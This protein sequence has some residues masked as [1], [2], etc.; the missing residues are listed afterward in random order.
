MKKETILVTGGA[1]YI[2]SHT[3][4]EL[5]GAGFDVFIVDDLSNSD[6]QAIEGIRRITGSQVPFEQ[7]DCCDREAL[8]G[9]FERHDFSSVIHFAASKAV[10]E[11][12][13]QPLKYYRNNILSLVNVVELTHFL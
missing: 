12:V 3:V 13:E 1:G 9:V 2:G 5:I 6:A 10:G 11:S 7:V 8:R 4:V